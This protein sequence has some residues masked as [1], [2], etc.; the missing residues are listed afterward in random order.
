MYIQYYEF[1]EKCTGL[2]HRPLIYKSNIHH[3]HHHCPYQEEHHFSSSISFVS[4]SPIWTDLSKVMSHDMIRFQL[5][6]TKIDP[7]A[8][9]LSIWNILCVN[10]HRNQFVIK[11]LRWHWFVNDV[12]RFWILISA[13]YILIQLWVYQIYISSTN[14]FNTIV[15][16]YWRDHFSPGHLRIGVWWFVTF[17]S[18]ACGVQSWLFFRLHYVVWKHCFKNLVFA[19]CILNDWP[20][21]PVKNPTYRCTFSSTCCLPSLFMII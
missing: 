5:Q 10:F 14:W 20:F 9:V 8:L 2:L 1:I 19:F 12:F 13:I 21:E 6:S 7:R 11:S 3:H 16:H 4:A 17:I 18:N 15:G